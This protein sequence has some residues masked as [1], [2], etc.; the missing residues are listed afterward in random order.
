MLV[1]GLSYPVA[2]GCLGLGWLG[3]RLIYFNN[4]TRVQSGQVVPEKPP[5]ET[6]CRVFP[7]PVCLAWTFCE[8]RVGS[9][10]AGRVTHAS[11][12]PGRLHHWEN[13]SLLSSSFPF[14]VV[15]KGYA[16]IKLCNVGDGLGKVHVQV[17]VRS[18]W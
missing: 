12:S 3:C 9:L 6:C 15:S 4:Y 10:F 16:R 1:A 17:L 8:G 13:V 7:V 18:S 11:A 5:M 2:A 14:P